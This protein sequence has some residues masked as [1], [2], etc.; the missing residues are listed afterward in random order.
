MPRPVTSAKRAA[1]RVHSQTAL[2]LDASRAAVPGDACVLDVKNPA[3]RQAKAVVLGTR[4]DRLVVCAVAADVLI[5][6]KPDVVRCL[7]RVPTC[8]PVPGFPVG[9]EVDAVNSPRLRKALDDCGISGG[10][11]LVRIKPAPQSQ[12]AMCHKNALLA[13]E[14][15]LGRPVFGYSLMASHR[16]A[17]VTLE[18]HSVVRLKDDSLVDVT[19]EILEARLAAKFFVE[20][21]AIDIYRLSSL[22]ESVL[23]SVFHLGRLIC[24]IVAPFHVVTAS[25]LEA[26]SLWC[27]KCSHGRSVR[28]AG[29]EPP[30]PYVS[31]ARA[32]RLLAL[33]PG[34][35]AD[36]GARLARGR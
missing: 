14:S 5:R 28:A 32:I 17:C 26:P 19:P 7:V 4:G 31:R 18:A 23:P 11:E 25:G 35:A 16:C 6:V 13:A 10:V 27:G 2:P 24:P 1:R 15:G 34:Q 29:E 30:P 12:P 36:G 8:M 22:P 33:A 9:M 21:P 3:F 20:D